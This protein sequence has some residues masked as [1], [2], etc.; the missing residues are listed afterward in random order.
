MSR[1]LSATII[2]LGIVFMWVNRRRAAKLMGA[3]GRKSGVNATAIWLPATVLG[4]ALTP[5]QIWP[6]WMFAI[7]GGYIVWGQ[8]RIPELSI[9]GMSALI[10]GVAS[11]G[12]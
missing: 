10:A 8:Q 9:F 3:V 1:A 6:L 7:G 2:S 11:A 5:H 12:L 4:A